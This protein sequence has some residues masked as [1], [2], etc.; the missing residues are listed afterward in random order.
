MTQRFI[1]F[2][3]MHAQQASLC[4]GQIP[5]PQTGKPEVNLEIARLFIDQ[6]VM[7]RAKT[8]GNL[9]EDEL[10]GIFSEQRYVKH[11]DWI[12]ENVFGQEKTQ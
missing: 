2:V 11:V 10:K 6:L 3:L 4:L 1:E 7:I 9:S 12:F 5:H 8:R